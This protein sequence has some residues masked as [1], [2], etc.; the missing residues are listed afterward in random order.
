MK[1][2][3]ILIKR[4]IKNYKQSLILILA[5]I[6]GTILGLILKNDAQV[7]SPLGDIFI[8]LLDLSVN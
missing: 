2:V 3:I 1:E 7:L 6:I 5:I 4:I 8:N